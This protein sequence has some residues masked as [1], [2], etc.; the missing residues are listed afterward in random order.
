MILCAGAIGTPAPPAALGNRP[1]RRA[2]GR[3]GRGRHELPAVGAN[4]IDHLA[5]GLLVATKGVET[6]ATAES[7]RNLVRWALRGR[8][9]L[10]SNLGEA[11]AFVRTRAGL[12]APDLEL[13]FAPV[14]FEDEG[15]KQPTEHGL[16]L[17]VVLLRPRAPA[18]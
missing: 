3:R 6:L 14:L 1:A 12:S 13:L 10:T 2:R 15:L 17:A 16:T 4:L 8:G 9:P 7:L 18:P 5:N 11:V